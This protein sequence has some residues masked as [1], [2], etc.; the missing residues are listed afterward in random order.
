MNHYPIKKIQ[1]HKDL[2][3]P[4]ARW[5]HQKWNIPES[6]Y[7]ESMEECLNNTS[8]VP[9]WYVVLNGQEIIAGLVYCTVHISQ[10]DLPEFPSAALASIDDATAS[11]HSAALQIENPF[12]VILLKMNG[13]AH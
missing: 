7:L 13:T 8:P 11:P 4:A 1:E 9:Q 2:L 12:G 6:A 5:F 3:K 10:N